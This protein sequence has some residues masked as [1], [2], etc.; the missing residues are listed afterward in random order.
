MLPDEHLIDGPLDPAWAGEW[1]HAAARG[2]EA[3][4]VAHF[5]GLIRA[6]AVDGRHVSAITYSAYRPMAERL[7]G[8]LEARIAGAEGLWALRVWHSMGTVAAGQASMLVAVAAAHRAE[9]FAGLRAAVEAVKASAPVWKYER[10][11]DAEGGRWV[12]GAPW[13][14]PAGHP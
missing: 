8:E 10:F 7:L 12:P 11:G 5:L 4:A 2:G 6:D 3:G 1:T 13:P 14:S 9:A